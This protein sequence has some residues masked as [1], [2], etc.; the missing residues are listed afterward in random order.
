VSDRYVYLKIVHPPTGDSDKPQTHVGRNIVLQV[1]AGDEVVGFLGGVR[2]VTERF[3]L[4]GVISLE[5]EV[6]AFHESI[7]KAQW[8]KP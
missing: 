8:P 5:L 3:P 1:V 2:G 4:D 6:S 7:E